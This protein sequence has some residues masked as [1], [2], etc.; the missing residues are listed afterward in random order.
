M[1]VLITDGT[2]RAALAAARSLV[3]A[4]HDVTVAAP[5][6][7]AL[8]TV[9]RGV[10]AVRLHRDAL[11]DPAGYVVELL[12]LAKAHDT[13]LVLPIT[14]ASVTALLEHRVALPASLIVLAP[15]LAA[16]RAASNKRD[17]LCLARDAGLDIPESL[18]LKTA[19][20]REQLKANPPDPA[21]FPVFVKPH[22][23]LVPRETGTG[24]KKIGVALAPDLDALHA[25]LA[26]L[27]LEAFPVI[28]QRRVHGVGE[29]LFL[30]RW[31]GNILAAFMHRRLREKPPS[32]GVS[33][34]RESIALD[35]VLLGAGTRLLEL[36]DWQGV[37]MIECKRD[38]TTGRHVLMEI[39]GRLWGSLQLAIDAGVDFPRLMVEAAGGCPVAPVTGYRVGV[40]SRWFWGDVD[41]LYQRLRHSRRALQL[42][43]HTGGRLAALWGFFRHAAQEREEI[44]RRR[45]PVPFLVETL[46]WFRLL[47]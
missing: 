23:S 22:A 29:G 32:G 20:E 39:N 11:R 12:L 7:L 14:D 25:T 21:L 46:S 45:D 18:V 6:R 3:A 8:A 16:Y 36:L 5:R 34:L 17:V 35:P 26:A 1:R 27:P 38:V 10:R 30:L 41:H 37:A 47:G 9:T 28:V 33:V 24:H 15:P 13:N 19:A 42:D 43:G 44:W 31:N 4:G 2:E 40:K